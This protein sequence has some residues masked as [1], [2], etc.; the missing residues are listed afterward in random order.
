MKT[1]RQLLVEHFRDNY[2]I[3]MRILR[4]A[5]D[6]IVDEEDQKF[7]FKKMISPVEKRAAEG[8]WGKYDTTTDKQKQIFKAAKKGDKSA[9]NYIWLRV[10]DENVGKTFWKSYLGP[11]GAARQRRISQGAFYDWAAIAYETLTTGNKDYTDTKGTL[12]TFDPD[13]YTSG[14]LFKNFGFYYW[15]K[16][17]NSAKESN[18]N[19]ATSGVS[20]TPGIKKGVTSEQSGGKAFSVGEYDPQ[21]MDQEAEDKGIY[22][23]PTGNSVID[24]EDMADFITAWRDCVSDSSVTTPKTG[25]IIP[26]ELMKVVILAGP[27]ADS[28][29]LLTD[30]YPQVS[31][32]TIA[33]YLKDVVKTMGDYDI[34]YADLMKAIKTLGEDKVA[35]YISA[36]KSNEQ[37]EGTEEPVVEPA[38]EGEK[39]TV[40][41]KI[42]KSPAKATIKGDVLE[43]F[44]TFCDDPHL[45]SSP[46]T[47]KTGTWQAGSLAYYML[48]DP[49]ITP[50]TFIEWNKIPG[51]WNEVTM[52]RV[53]KML[54]KRGMDWSMIE[55]MPKKQRDQ[56]AEMIGDDA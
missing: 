32:N 20:G 24:N 21:L 42:N 15:N 4:E 51:T 35:S 17:R 56:L 44:R 28:F 29:S 48:K 9:I 18:F 38:T 1:Q 40:E 31:R 45:W 6:N 2:E 36:G 14:D 47:N 53:K 39:D 13:K 43:S 22:D 54:K 3:N 55:K 46:R 12:E 27:N 8:K 37:I 23:D 49:K 34:E 50:E 33:N 5:N 16:L 52:N 7:D 41:K 11:N 26:I 25:G 19:D 30:R 10:A